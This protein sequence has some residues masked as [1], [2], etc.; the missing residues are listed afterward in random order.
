MQLDAAVAGRERRGVGR[1]LDPRF[2]VED[3]EQAVAGGDR[4]LRHPHRHPQH[5]RRPGE[6]RQVDVEGG[7]VA[8]AEAAGDHLAAADQQHQGDPELGEE[9]EERREEGLQPGRVDALVEDPGDGSAEAV[10]LVLLAGERL[11]DPD[12]GDVLLGLGGQ[13][14]DPLLDLLHRRAR[15]PV[16]AGGGV[17]DQRGRGQRDQRQPGVDVEH[18]RA[19]ED[20]REDVLGDEDQPVA[21]EEADRLEV[22]RRPRHQLPGLL[23]VEEAELEPLQMGVE[24]LSEVELDRERDPPGDDAPDQGQADPEDAGDGDHDREREE[25]GLVAVFDRVDRAP[26]QVRDQDRHPH[27]RPR[28]G[29]RTPQFAAIRAQKA[30]QTT[31]GL[32]QSTIQSEVKAETGALLEAFGL[33]AGDFPVPAGF[34]ARGCPAAAGSGSW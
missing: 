24:E 20:D 32:H 15:D 3:F 27:R 33:G 9:A 16:V 29:Q 1:A 12:P 7:E 26:D 30:H 23:G 21:E 5:P 13:F 28:K 6:H 18:H 14:G 22:D 4:P 31:V 25:V 34:R 10:Q 8:E 19:G 11:H 17:D 2:A